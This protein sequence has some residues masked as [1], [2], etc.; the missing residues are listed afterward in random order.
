MGSG[1]REKPSSFRSNESRPQGQRDLERF[2]DSLWTAFLCVIP[3]FR[4]SNPW[5]VGRPEGPGGAELGALKEGGE[6]GV[7]VNDCCSDP[8][9]KV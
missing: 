4:F 9:R 8:Q 3:S 5:T 7:T 1:L 2:G 6:G